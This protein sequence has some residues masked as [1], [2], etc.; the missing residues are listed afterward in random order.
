METVSP[1][2]VGSGRAAVPMLTDSFINNRLMA[3]LAAKEGIDRH[4]SVRSRLET[5]LDR[6]WNDAYWSEVVR[7]T[8]RVDDTELMKR[9]PRMEDMVSLQQLIVGTREEAEQLRARALKGEDFG[10]LIKAH[11]LGLT[12]KSGGMVGFVKKD[13]A[14]YEPAFLTTLF[15]MKTGE[16]TPV[17][18]IGIG[19]T[20]ARVL[21]RK[22][23]DQ[24]RKE[25]FDGNRARLRQEREKE[26]WDKAKD[27]LLRKHKVVVNRSVV[28]AYMKAREKNTP[29]TAMMGKTVLTIDGAP[30]TVADLTDP[31]GLGIVHGSQT[32]DLIVRKRVDDYVVAREVE[33]LHLK[34][35]F[36]EV[37]LRERLQR[38]NLLAR[39]YIDHQC[40]DLKV[41][42]ADRKAFYEANKGR[43]VQERSLDV[44][45][46]ETRSRNRADE[47]YKELRNRVSFADVADR[48]S[49]NK[50]L[51][52]GRLGFIPEDKIAPEFASVRKLKVGEYAKT[53]IRLHAKSENVD[54]YVIPMLNAVR[55]K[56]TL[57]L[58]EVDRASIDKAVMARKREDVV[59]RILKELK[60]S[61]KV[62]FM[63]EYDRF[64]ASLEEH[65]K[66]QGGIR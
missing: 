6:L 61:N 30:M 14:M 47:I 63:P 65:T 26:L 42:P 2:E 12:A 37:S 10:E 23:A 34:D 4:P 20:V 45:L 58:E 52:G 38:E 21:G 39:A 57:P 8:I 22:T 50:K 56:R 64:A 25:W 51:K 49:D 62:I 9:A 41:T 53:P 66:K 44:S 43:F 54:L 24:S 60:R 33:S 32:L 7:P 1:E 19:Y 18:K 11:S 31:S 17:T 48:W 13:S 29:L 36:P 5:R 3:V 59:S 16:F 55:E 46:V 28:D 35:K 40:R 27:R 15:G